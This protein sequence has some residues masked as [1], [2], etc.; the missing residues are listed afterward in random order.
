MRSFS[1]DRHKTNLQILYDLY[2][3]VNTKT[4]RWCETLKVYGGYVTSSEYILENVHN[5]MSL[6][7]ETIKLHFLLLHPYT[8][9]HFN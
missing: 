8:E 9:K 7:C 6:N 1:G 2:E 3:Y 4:Q 5:D